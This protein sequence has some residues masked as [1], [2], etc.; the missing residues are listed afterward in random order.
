MELLSSGVFQGSWSVNYWLLFCKLLRRLLKWIYS[1]LYGSL[2]KEK[3]AMWVVEAIYKL[4]YIIFCQAKNTG[5]MARAQGKHREFG[6]DWSMAT[7]THPSPQAG[8]ETGPGYPP[9]SPCTYRHLWKYYLQPQCGNKASPPN[10]H[11]GQWPITWQQSQWL[12]FA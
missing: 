8:P 6:I 11:P 4:K 3:M 9:P 12:W 7:L 1:G 2:G 5:K 10:R